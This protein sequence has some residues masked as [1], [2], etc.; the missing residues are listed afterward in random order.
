VENWCDGKAKDVMLFSGTEIPD[1]IPIL[2]EID[3]CHIPFSQ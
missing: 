1:A 2:F 3:S